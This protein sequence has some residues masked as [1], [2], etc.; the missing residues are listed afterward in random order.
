M[1]AQQ[2]GYGAPSFDLVEQREIKGFWQNKR[3]DLDGLGLVV[4]ALREEQASGGQILHP[5][6]GLL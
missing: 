4:K 3:L 2:K 1:G 6:H 5:T